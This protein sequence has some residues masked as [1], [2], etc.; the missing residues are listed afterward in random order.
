M[1][2]QG[3]YKANRN[4][5]VWGT[6]CV[7]LYL[8]LLWFTAGQSLVRQAGLT[9][10][11]A[12]VSLCSILQLLCHFD[13]GRFLRAAVGRA[14]WWIISFVFLYNWC[15]LLTY[16]VS[17]FLVS[18]IP[19]KYRPCFFFPSSAAWKLERGL[20]VFSAHLSGSSSRYPA[21]VHTSW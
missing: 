13:N 11:P 3:K 19:I 5:L 17:A 1:L 7:W 10:Q 12:L 18:N 4:L 15:V 2:H 9:K 8:C 14:K 21:N 16:S 20:S 6:K